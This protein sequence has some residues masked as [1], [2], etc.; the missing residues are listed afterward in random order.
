MHHLWSGGK[1]KRLIIQLL[2]NNIFFPSLLYNCFHVEINLLNYWI[3]RQ[4]FISIRKLTVRGWGDPNPL[5]FSQLLQK[6]TSAWSPLHLQ[7]TYTVVY[8][9]PSLSC[10]FQ[11]VIFSSS[12]SWNAD[13]FWG[14]Y[15]LVHILVTSY[16][17]LSPPF[18]DSSKTI[19]IALP[20]SIQGNAP[21][22][23]YLTK[24]GK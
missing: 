3:K 4:H 13:H 16:A 20:H 15:S 7:E 21:Q 17:R 11:Y 12:Y 18:H 10:Y 8:I 14:N 22:D 24:K 1:R 9:I 19:A 5:L 23:R 6:Y 2:P